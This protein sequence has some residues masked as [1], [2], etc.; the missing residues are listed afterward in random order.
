MAKQRLPRVDLPS[1]LRDQDVEIRIS[2]DGKVL[3]IN[4]VQEGCVLRVHNVKTLTIADDR[5]VGRRSRQSYAAEEKAN[6]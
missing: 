5:S 2:R 6:V 1:D 3:W 4:T